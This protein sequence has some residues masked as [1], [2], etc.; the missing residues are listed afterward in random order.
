MIIYKKDRNGSKRKAGSTVNPFDRVIATLPDLTAMISKVYVNEIDVS[1]VKPGQ[2]VN[3]N[4]DAFPKNAYT[5]SVIS[6]GNIGEVLPNSDAK[7]FEVQIRVDGSDPALRPSMTTSNKIIIE[8]FDNV[9]FIPTECVQAGADSIPFVYGKNKTKQVVVL[10]GSN[11]KNVIVE[12]GLKPGSTI[13]VIPPEDA[14]NFRLV[15]EELIPTIHE[16]NK[17]RKIKNQV[18]SKL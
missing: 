8:T 17:A 12:Q 13:F 5:G 16:R 2:K 15:G 14:E 9:S 1:K 18:F 7:M 11:E 10:G 3:I 4:V 6:V